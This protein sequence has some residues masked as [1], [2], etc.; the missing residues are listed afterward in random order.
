MGKNIDTKVVVV[1]RNGG[2]E[3]RKKADG[4]LGAMHHALHPR[5]CFISHE[6]VMLI[7]ASTDQDNLM[8]VS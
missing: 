4:R 5:G 6:L 2:V 3:H 1:V 8:S 7:G